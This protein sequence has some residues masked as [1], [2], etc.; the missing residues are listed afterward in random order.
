[1]EPR[2]RLP[3]AASGGA[4]M[5][6]YAQCVALLLLVGHSGVVHGS[7]GDSDPEFESAAAACA[8]RCPAAAQEDSAGMLAALA[9][10]AGWS[11][12]EECLYTTMHAHTAA[13]VAAGRPVL[14]YFGK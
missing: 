1:M 11:C 9:A 13:G 8:E 10:G 3:L 2:L 14:Q 12:A 5:R 4:A 6:R 7:A